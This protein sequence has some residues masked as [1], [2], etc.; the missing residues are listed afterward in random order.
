MVDNSFSVLSFKQFS[1]SNFL[2]INKDLLY[3]YGAEASIFIS[4][5]IDK[6][7]YFH[8][9]GDLLE[10]VWFFQTHEKQ[11]KQIK[12]MSERSLRGY[13]R[14][15]RELGV[16]EIKMAGIP[17]KEFY[18]INIDVLVA[19]VEAKLKAMERDNL[20]ALSLSQG[21]TNRS[22]SALPEKEGLALPE[23][24]PLIRKPYINKTYIEISKDI[25][26]SD[27]FESPPVCD[28]LRVKRKR[29]APIRE[30]PKP[31]EWITS[32]WKKTILDFWNQ[33][34]ETSRHLDRTTKAICRASKDLD[35]LKR[36][37]FFNINKLSDAFINNAKIPQSWIRKNRAFTEREIFIAVSK[38]PLLFKPG[39][40]PTN[41]KSLPRSLEA[42]IYNPH[43][44]SSMLLSI[45]ANPT[46]KARA[47]QDRLPQYTACFKERGLLKDFSEQEME[48]VYRGI[49]I[50]EKRA[51]EDGIFDFVSDNG[52]ENSKLKRIIGVGSPGK[53]VPMFLNYAIY[54]KKQNRLDKKA[55]F[56]PRGYFQDFLKE[57]QG[58]YRS[59]EVNL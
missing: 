59:F 52:F 58:Y 8:S 47:D 24:A 25:S 11:M 50:M 56:A 9:Q 39:Y 1:S 51:L 49:R 45:L 33:M 4:N 57:L 14:M 40:A 34:P 44:C 46:I 3:V 53:L 19:D 16:L 15:F 32:G 12:H 17:C 22:M 38:Y 41:K 55:M 6:F 54:L 37:T 23:K 42:F 31:K 26:C 10:G 21:L 28:I 30:L 2:S 13:K 48:Q 29:N 36:G 5:L 18:K 43:R 27:S 35:Y 7:L 20:S